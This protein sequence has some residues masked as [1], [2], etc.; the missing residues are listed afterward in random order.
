MK[1]YD[2]NKS[3]TEIVNENINELL[4]NNYSE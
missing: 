3:G 2:S 4:R 1:M